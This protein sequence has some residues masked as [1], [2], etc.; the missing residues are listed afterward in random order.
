[1]NEIVGSHDL[2]LVTLD[3]LRYDVAQELAAAGRIPHLAAHLPT[4]GWERRH[5][6]GSFTYASHQAIF[7]GFLPTPATPGPHPRLFAARFAGS[8]TTADGTYVFDTPD[9][10]SGL[11]AAG[12]RTVCIGGVGFF[13]K[14]APLGSVLPGMFQESHWEPEFGVP[15]PTSFEAQIAR[16]EEV[17]AGLPD[18]QRLFLFVNVSALH[19]PNWFHLPGATREA[20]DSRATHAAALEYVDRHIGRLFTA[21]SSRRRCFAIVCSDHGTTY[22]DD[23]FTGHRLG[24]EAVWTVPYAHFFLEAEAQR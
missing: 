18:E 7:A 21:A 13:N 17:V 6:P 12:Y 3:T 4:G 24:H 15:S 14:Q 1:M 11:A 5:A 19:Q 2:L 23:G 9:L 20:G 22:G 10:V 16:A 8:E